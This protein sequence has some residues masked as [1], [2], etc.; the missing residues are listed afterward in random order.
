LTPDKSKP[1]V[2]ESRSYYE[3]FSV[4]SPS[5]DK[6][7]GDRCTVGFWNLTGHDVTVSIEGQARPLPR[8]KSLK[9]QVGRQFVWRVEGHEAQNETVPIENSGIEIVLRRP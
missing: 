1:E 7:L 5:T 2:S 4:R 9:L 3:S 6:T 8:G